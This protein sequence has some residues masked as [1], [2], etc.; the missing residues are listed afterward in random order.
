M[1]AAGELSSPVIARG[2]E[3][4]W[5]VLIHFI[6]SGG[7]RASGLTGWQMSI[8][9]TAGA[10]T[11]TATGVATEVGA[12]RRAG[13]SALSAERSSSQTLSTW[14]RRATS[15]TDEGVDKSDPRLWTCGVTSGG[16]DGVAN[17]FAN[18]VT[19][20]SGGGAIDDASVVADGFLMTSVLG[21]LAARQSLGDV[22]HDGVGHELVDGDR[23]LAVDVLELDDELGQAKRVNAN[24]E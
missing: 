19:G 7:G 2:N 9:A 10:A 17:G 3:P 1:I 20:R 4:T 15:S 24:V 8:A 12:S 11:A 23:P 18:G 22:A 13:A 14:L 16:A 21:G 5:V 6:W